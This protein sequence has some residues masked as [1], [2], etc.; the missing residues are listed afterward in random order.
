MSIQ[1]I[2]SIYKFS[3]KFYSMKVYFISSKLSIA[4]VSDLFTLYLQ[5]EFQL[6]L[7]KNRKKENLFANRVIYYLIIYNI[8]YLF[9]MSRFVIYFF[10]LD[11]LSSRIFVCS[12][13]FIWENPL[14]L[15]ENI[16]KMSM[17]DLFKL[18]PCYGINFFM[19]VT[20]ALVLM[21]LQ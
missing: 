20:E 7:F 2:S 11:L 15:K 21:L 16:F 12:H 13:V 5:E 6:A 9:S 14:V 19:S 3:H 8:F 1:F 17:I 10:C 18:I 4:L